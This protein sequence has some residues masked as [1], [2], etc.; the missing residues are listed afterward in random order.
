MSGEIHADVVF[1]GLG[2]KTGKE[3]VDKEMVLVTVEIQRIASLRGLVKIIGF[4]RIADQSPDKGGAFVVKTVEI[5]NNNPLTN[6]K[7]ILKSKNILYIS[8]NIR[9][10]MT[11]SIRAL[12]QIAKI[13]SYIF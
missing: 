6:E 7:F 5:E 4:H 12:Y 13:T 2:Q 9:N 10:I 8:I 11:V 3:P 1:P